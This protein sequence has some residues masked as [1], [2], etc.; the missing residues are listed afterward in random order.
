MYWYELFPV[1]FLKNSETRLNISEY[2]EFSSTKTRSA[3][4]SNSHA[5]VQAPIS[6]AA[7]LF[8]PSVVLSEVTVHTAVSFNSQ[9]IFGYPDPG[10]LTPTSASYQR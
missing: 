5:I 4:T 6:S 2:V 10:L 3:L 7:G 1:K 8:T 9:T